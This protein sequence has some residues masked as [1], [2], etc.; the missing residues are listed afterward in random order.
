MSSFAL[1]FFVLSNDYFQKREIC[2]LP[3]NK[4]MKW[5]SVSLAVWVTLNV[6][7]SILQLIALPLWIAALPAA[8][9]D[10]F[11]VFQVASAMFVV[12]FGVTII[13]LKFFNQNSFSHFIRQL[14]WRGMG[15]IILTGLLT[16]LNGLLVTISAPVS[17][18]PPVIAST[19]PNIMFI[20]FILIIWWLHRRRFLPEP[21]IYLS[22]F[23]SLEFVLFAIMYVLCTYCVVV[24]TNE[25]A[26]L[27]GQVY[28]WLIFTLGILFAYLANQSQEIFFK[29]EVFDGSFNSLTNYIFCVVLVSLVFTLLGTW[30][31]CTSSTYFCVSF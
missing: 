21:K 18:T 5:Q 14:S 3:Q 10:P 16:A 31:D 2:Q 7:S 27:G 6:I 12:F 23:W 28:W 19:L 13:F 20:F 24:A 8:C 22:D 30:I 29:N 26:A 9:S 17:R 1:I 4:I 15:L 11:V 25:Q